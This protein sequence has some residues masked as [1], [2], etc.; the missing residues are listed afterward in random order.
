M[1]MKLAVWPQASDSGK[2]SGLGFCIYKLEEIISILHSSGGGGGELG[3]TQ[4]QGLKEKNACELARTQAGATSGCVLFLSPSSAPAP[5]AG[6]A[7]GV[8]Q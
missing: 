1:E 2:P 4:L 7:E 3:G 5:P 6:R 8:K